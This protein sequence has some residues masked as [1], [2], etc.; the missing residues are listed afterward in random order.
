LTRTL[1]ESRTLFVITNTVLGTRA[2]LALAVVLAAEVMDLLDATI[3]NVA[4]PSIRADLHGSYAFMQWLAAGYTLAFAVGLVTG[5]RLGDIYGR[6]RLFVIGAAGFTACSLLCAIVP[7]GAPTGTLILFRVLQGAF[8]AVLIPQGF[9]ILKEVFP[10]ADLGKAFGAFGP[11]MGLAAVGGPILAGALIG[12]DV[13]GTGWRMIFLV[14]VPLGVLAVVGAVRVLPPSRPAPS[15]RLDLPGTVLLSAALVLLVYPLVQGRE[16]G[17]PAWTLT[18][19]ALCLPMLLIFIVYEG[20][21]RRSALVEPSLFGKPVFIAG[22]GAGLLLSAGLVGLT[23]VVGVHLQVGLGFTPLHAGLSLAPWA[24][25]IAIGSVLAGTYGARR[26]RRVLRL[27]LL[28]MVAGLA[29]QIVTL[30]H[31]GTGLTGWDLAPALL[32]T[33]VGTGLAITPFFD[34]VLAN[35]DE[36]EL[37][38][39]SGTVNAAQQLGGAIGVAGLATAYFALLARHGATGAAERVMLLTLGLLALIGLVTPALPARARD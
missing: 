17:W 26:G 14:N 25:G 22:L 1:F 18:C 36:H 4:G 16:L 5:G 28:V 9:G 12:A 15:I 8:G 20:K 10:P 30:H 31:T 33:G 19:L 35:V 23:F 39:A 2:W 21:H 3:I 27:G 34:L 37:G 13:L 24:L 6:R 7:V 29:A 11:V 32:V 38:S